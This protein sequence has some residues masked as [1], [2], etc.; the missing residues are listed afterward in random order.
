ML[1]ILF[2]SLRRAH[3]KAA[4]NYL[5]NESMADKQV[6]FVVETQL[7]LRPYLLGR[8]KMH[9]LYKL[10]RASD[11]DSLH[12]D[13]LVNTELER[14][15]FEDVQNGALEDMQ[16]FLASSKDINLCHTTLKGASRLWKA[17]E[18]GHEKAV[19]KI[20]QHPGVD[21]NKVR[22]GIKTTPLY[23][24]AHHG[25]DGV[26]RA[27]IE[28]PKIDINLGN[29]LTGVPPLLM[30]VQAGNEAVVRILLKEK[31]INVNQ[32]C[33]STGDNSLLKACDLGH[34]HIV[35]LLLAVVGVDVN[36]SRKDG[37]TALSIASYHKHDAIVQMLKNTTGAHKR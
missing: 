27:L 17:A 2:K 7:L 36:R 8:E 16:T 5:T 33:T 26:V 37:S 28:H 35:A 1:C 9:L 23:I 15:S 6:Q 11:V 13:F 21:P 18:D 31:N 24:A 14:R 30:A 10:C 32:A 22:V 12:A 25:H 20:L 34:E 3:I 19:R 4:L 29:I